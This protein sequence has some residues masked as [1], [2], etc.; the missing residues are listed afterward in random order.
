ML[1]ILKNGPRNIRQ[2]LLRDIVIVVS[3]VIIALIAMTYYLGSNVRE[4]ASAR[5]KG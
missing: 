1:N 5:I 3:I 2:R 4:H